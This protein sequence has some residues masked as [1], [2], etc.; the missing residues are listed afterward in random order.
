MDEMDAGEVRTTDTHYTH[1]SALP[2][3]LAVTLRQKEKDAWEACQEW[4]HGAGLLCAGV[5]SAG[6]CS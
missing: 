5:F 4:S 2:S 1:K 3:Q 6:T